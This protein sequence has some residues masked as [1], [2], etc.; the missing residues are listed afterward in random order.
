MPPDFDLRLTARSHGWYRL[1]PLAWDAGAGVLRVSIAVDDATAVTARVRQRRDVLT[2]TIAAATPLSP[3][4]RQRVLAAIRRMVDLD[5]DLSD[6]H[7][8]ARRDP[9]LAW[10]AE[11]GAGRLLRAPSAFE[12]LIKIVCTTNCSWSLTETMVARLV[13]RAGLPAPGGR[14]FPTP[15]ALA[16]RSERFFRE[17]VR[18]GYRAP[19]LLRLAR[20]V[21]R[22]EVNPDGW[23]DRSDVDALR[24]ELLALPGVGPYAAAHLLRL[25]GH[26]DDPGIDAWVRARFQ[27]IYNLR[28]PPTDARIVRRYRAFGRWLGLALWL[29]VTRDWHVPQA[30]AQDAAGPA[31]R[32]RRRAPTRPGR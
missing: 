25:C 11:R 6:F 15:A 21:A 32:S 3:P 19:H 1:A 16:R 17:V 23:A 18:A 20:A 12:D 29:D 14:A 27:R 24:R 26:Y 4:Q 22:G 8:L 5:A 7:A 13:D 2:G 10:A 9:R 31:R 28:R 30:P